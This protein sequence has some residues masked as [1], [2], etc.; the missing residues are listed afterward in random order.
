[1]RKLICLFAL[2]LAVATVGGCSKNAEVEDFVKE[3]DSFAKEIE[4]KADKDGPAGAKKAFEARK[5]TI[6]KKF[7]A[8]KD[9]RGFQVSE[10]NMKKLTESVT[11]ST[12]SICGLQL[13][14]IMDEEKSKGYKELC[15]EYAKLLQF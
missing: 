14:A 1:V 2:P 12:T 5:D 8:I 4:E 3:N 9:A 6:K 11:K 10:E 7:D 15:D 13:K